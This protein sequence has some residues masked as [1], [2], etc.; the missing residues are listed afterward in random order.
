MCTFSSW[1]PLF[2]GPGGDSGVS[3][4]SVCAGLACKG[5]ELECNAR[6]RNC[7]K[8]SSSFI[9]IAPCL[10]PPYQLQNSCFVPNFY[11]SLNLISLDLFVYFLSVAPGM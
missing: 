6:D 2:P 10:V 5:V 4:E 11:H 8:F 3:W 1:R 9:F 7:G